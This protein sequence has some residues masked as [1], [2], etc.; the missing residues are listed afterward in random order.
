MNHWG[1]YFK[2]HNVCTLYLQN[3]ETENTVAL[4]IFEYNFVCLFFPPAV[5]VSGDKIS[6]AE[7]IIGETIPV[8]LVAAPNGQLV[9]NV[10]PLSQSISGTSL[11]GT[12]LVSLEEL[13][14]LQRQNL[15]L[16][17]EI[18][19]NEQESCGISVPSSETIKNVS[20]KGTNYLSKTEIVS[21]SSD[22]ATG[23][24]DR[25]PQIT[26]PAVSVTATA[27]SK[28]M[29]I[30]TKMTEGPNNQ[31]PQILMI[32]QGQ[33]LT[34]EQR[35]TIL[36]GTQKNE[37]D[38]Q[39]LSLESQEKRNLSLEA[40]FQVT[41]NELQNFSRSA[42]LS[43]PQL[44]I[45][46]TRNILSN[47]IL[48]SNQ[49]PSFLTVAGSSQDIPLTNY[50][51][52]AKKPGK[53]I[54]SF[55]GRGCAKPSVLQKHLR[56]HTGERP[57]PC[58]ECGFHFKT[59]S[60]LYKHCKSRTHRLKLGLLRRGASLK[61]KSVM[62][63][64]SD[65]AGEISADSES[66]I[67]SENE[68][69]A[70]SPE[71]RVQSSKESE[72]KDIQLSR[73]VSNEIKLTSELVDLPL[74]KVETVQNQKLHAMPNEDMLNLQSVVIDKPK[75]PNKKEQAQNHVLKEVVKYLGKPKEERPKIEV[76]QSIPDYRR[77][78]E[79][80]KS[81]QDKLKAKLERSSS[82]T[83]PP[84]IPNL[85]RSMSV[86][87]ERKSFET[88][89]QTQFLKIAP[90]QNRFP[91]E[92]FHH[93]PQEKKIYVHPSEI[94]KYPAKSLRDITQNSMQTSSVVLPVSIVTPKPSPNLAG[95]IETIKVPNSEVNSAE[96]TKALQDLE[97]LTENFQQASKA[98]TK[99]SAAVTTLSDGSCQ[100]VIH[101]HPQ[102]QQ[103]AQQQTA[104]PQTTQPHIPIIPQQP[105]IMTQI[106]RQ[107]PK[108][109]SSD[110]L[111]ER[112]Q[113]LIKTNA[114]IVNTAMAD[115]PRQRRLSRQN[116][117][118]LPKIEPQTPKLPT[119]PPV[120]ANL[121]R[122]VNLDNLPTCLQNSVILPNFTALSQRSSGA[123]TSTSVAPNIDSLGQQQTPLFYILKPDNRIQ[124]S[125]ET[126][127][128][129]VSGKTLSSLSQT[130]VATTYTVSGT[131][132]V[133]SKNHGTPINLS[134]VQNITTIPNP[135]ISRQSSHPTGEAFSTMTAKDLDGHEITIKIKL[136]NPD[137]PP[138]I[139][140]RKYSTSSKGLNLQSSE[141]KSSMKSLNQM[142]DLQ[143]GEDKCQMS[144][145]SDVKANNTSNF[146]CVIC[147]SIFEKNQSLKI[148]QMLHCKPIEVEVDGEKVK[149]EVNKEAVESCDLQILNAEP[150]KK[151]RPKG[152][153]TLR[154]QNVS[155]FFSD[156]YTKSG[157][158]VK[159]YGSP[160]VASTAV[161][162]P[163]LSPSWVQ[164]QIPLSNTGGTKSCDNMG[165][166]ILTV[167]TSLPIS[168]SQTNI[169][170]QA[171]SNV[172]VATQPAEN[173]TRSDND[174]KT[175]WKNTL[176]QKILMKRSMST[177]KLSSPT[178]AP[179]A[180]LQT[181]SKVFVVANPGTKSTTVDHET[182]NEEES[183]AAK[184]HPL[185]L[186]YVS[187]KPVLPNIDQSKQVYTA[188]PLPDSPRIIETGIMEE[189]DCIIQ[190]KHNFLAKQISESLNIIVPVVMEQAFYRST[191]I[192]SGRIGL[193]P[194]GYSSSGSATRFNDK[195]SKL[196]AALTGSEPFK[197]SIW[198]QKISR[199]RSLS[200]NDAQISEFKENFPFSLNGHSFPSLKA[201][202]YASFCC[203]QRPQPMYVMQNHSK[204]VSMYSNWRV[205][206]HDPNPQ[207]LTSKMLLSLYSKSYSSNPV[208]KDAQQ[209]SQKGGLLTHSSYWTF[210]QNQKGGKTDLE[211]NKGSL[212]RPG[213]DN[214]SN[215]TP[216][217]SPA[218]KKQKIL[219]VEGGFKSLAEYT[220]IR[221]RGRGK[222]VCSKC[223]IRCKKPSML[224]KH[225]RTHTDLRPYHCKTCRFYFKTKGNL[226][227]HM[228]SKAHHKKCVEKGIVPVPT[229]I[230]DTQI[231]QEALKMQCEF[232]KKA[233]I[234]T[235]TEDGATGGVDNDEDTDDADEMDDD[236]VPM[237]EDGDENDVDDDNVDEDESSDIKMEGVEE[238]SKDMS[239]R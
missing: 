126:S 178:V 29:S 132:M 19:E 199:S 234:K 195:L 224:K 141:V 113:K 117:D 47:K 52:P 30:L 151:G 91:Q 152:S 14:E 63:K 155:S 175:M 58:M 225:I 88:P 68:T 84:R 222:Y 209:E 74:L 218:T 208:Y 93:I 203:L 108:S 95:H 94:H 148:H 48:V 110:D 207:G 3:I 57:Y 238:S 130:S 83:E 223:G 11:P 79:R 233:K 158:D 197:D 156:E 170:P 8:N 118:I 33:S 216:V 127:N 169:Q 18:D 230:D 144:S 129:I 206:P 231:D 98:G 140:K 227:K 1:S 66:E 147:G 166:G 154:F 23:V 100:V 82:L 116:S 219:G 50:K 210:K 75:D 40:L 201:S 114:A 59:K 96:S 38:Q 179:S 35:K 122:G 186:R 142:K 213:G 150:R 136:N 215:S 39:S 204:K 174:K 128:S 123:V 12:D 107:E 119:T 211:S 153:K 112:I 65:T 13:Q 196:K 160:Q 15:S 101:Y 89:S 4:Y 134:Q 31:V 237:D 200:E 173:E 176:K 125:K 5:S 190:N 172:S 69:D 41:D 214:S 76:P 226:T 115:G 24:S 86:L 120:G 146:T 181:K 51:K 99:L 70:Q 42:P 188:E 145:P 60:N 198:N 45:D 121:L 189:E 124:P 72:I 44:I 192:D 97:K 212:K 167:K 21:S 56:A 20:I 149:M 71:V 163:K 80:S 92:N 111:S 26:T 85:K 143:D 49:L 137:E 90:K 239:N 64:S 32:Q 77:S 78:M 34:E 36:L 185:L 191:Q 53:Y 67:E 183:R 221:G 25:T 184:N 235:K 193:E 102:Q 229:Q 22:I 106:L 236:G 7:N 131:S 55:C 61:W 10:Q 16:G 202:T 28:K 46:D 87:N 164:S 138:E 109:A 168:T 182:K 54:C 205:A 27:S 232:S 81:V 162:L 2:V 43:P 135:T 17:E 104:Q 217:V 9:I 37:K 159:L 73:L 220:Y 180:I 171:P 62:K 105:P 194:R 6:L 177:D 133:T 157:G 103:T 165:G 161:I 187:T 139:T 228:K